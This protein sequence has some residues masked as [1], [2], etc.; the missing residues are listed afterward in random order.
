M[1][2]LPQTVI[3]DSSFDRWKSHRIEVNNK[4]EKY[5]YHTI[6]LIDVGANEIEQIDSV[7]IIIS[8]ASDEYLDSDGNYYLPFLDIGV[9]RIHP[10]PNH[11]QKYSI[12]LFNHIYTLFKN[13]LP[14]ELSI[15]KYLI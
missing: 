3:T 13:Y 11:N 4:F 8:S 10:G 1:I 9:D 7:P 12:N 14:K 6:P 2:I 5:Y 15:P